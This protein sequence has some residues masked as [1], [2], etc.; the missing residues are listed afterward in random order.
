M[1]ARILGFQVKWEKQEEFVKVLKNDI[2][3]ILRKQT[4]FLEFLPFF[5]EKMKEEKT[6][7][8][9]F[10]ATKEDAEKYEKEFYP[11]INEIVKPYLATP[12]VVGFYTVET[13]LCEHFVEALAA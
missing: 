10:W 5:P 4:G 7:A 6:I 11:K 13:A 8:I 1:F 3:P 9:S 12:V 2:L